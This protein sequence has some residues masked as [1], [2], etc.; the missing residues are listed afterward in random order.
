MLAS[1]YDTTNKSQDIFA[2]ADAAGSK[3]TYDAVVDA[4]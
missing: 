2:Y 4:S 1:T 3:K